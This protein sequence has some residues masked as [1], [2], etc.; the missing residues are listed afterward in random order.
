MTHHTIAGVGLQ[1]ESIQRVASKVI[2]RKQYTIIWHVDD[3]KISHV[4]P[5]DV[6]SVLDILWME[7]GK[8]AP[9][10]I[11][12]GKIRNYL[13]MTLDFSTKVKQ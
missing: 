12:C 8:Q 6:T 11:N 7:F 10:T 3:L 13:G 4:D 9:L 5:E 1:A 2:N